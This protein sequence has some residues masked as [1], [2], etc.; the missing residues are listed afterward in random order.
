MKNKFTDF[1]NKLIGRLKAADERL[2]KVQAV[3]EL[4]PEL[5]MRR[6]KLELEPRS[7]SASEVKAIRNVFSV[8][9]AVFAALIQVSKRTLEKW[10]QGTSDVPGPVAVLL[11]DM[12]ANPD[13]WRRQF[14]GLMK[15]SDSN[16]TP[17]GRKHATH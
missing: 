14:H 16:G 1:E 10:E 17:T 8:S 4:A 12:L 6:V 13:H 11:G 7:V 15:R 9:Q 5:T 3:E 2:A